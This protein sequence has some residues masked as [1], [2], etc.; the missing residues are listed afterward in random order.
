ME[1][2]PRVL[3]RRTTGQIKPIRAKADGNLWRYKHNKKEHSVLVGHEDGSN[4]KAA[5]VSRFQGGPSVFLVEG[6]GEAAPFIY[7]PVQASASLAT[8]DEINE[9]AEN[10]YIQQVDNLT[11]ER[12]G[13]EIRG[14]IQ[15]ILLCLVLLGIFWVNSSIDNLGEWI[16][17]TH[18]PAPPP[19]TPG[20]V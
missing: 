12:R 11:R 16:Q 14:W 1:R 6:K 8:A 9:M 18:P 7:D 15:T 5:R 17:A 3:L 2:A 20:A 19:P 10:N 13:E 4:G